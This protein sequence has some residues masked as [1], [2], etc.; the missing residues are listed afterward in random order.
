MGIHVAGLTW[1]ISGPGEDIRVLTPGY[2]ANACLDPGLLSRPGVLLQSDCVRLGRRISRHE[3]S[4]LR[5]FVMGTR[6]AYRTRDKRLTPRV[7]PVECAVQG[8]WAKD[9]LCRYPPIRILHVPVWTVQCS[10]SDRGST[11]EGEVAFLHWHR[12]RLA[13]CPRECPG[14][15]GGDRLGCDSLR[16][17]ETSTGGDTKPHALLP[18]LSNLFH[19]RRLVRTATP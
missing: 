14:N 6:K 17:A 5:R 15:R 1:P 2:R 9:R 8:G 13:R 3:V 4:L 12:R 10:H 16:V 19:R 18:Q 7:S 11:K